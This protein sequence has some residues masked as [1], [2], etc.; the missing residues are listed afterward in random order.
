[1]FS[2]TKSHFYKSG[3]FGNF[4]LKAKPKYYFMSGSSPLEREV[5]EQYLINTIGKNNLLNKVNPLGG[6]V[7]LYDK[8]WE[9]VLKKYNL[10]P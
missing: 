10:K 8:M 9:N 2:R 1:M 5:F 7:G 4:T 6:R 3:K